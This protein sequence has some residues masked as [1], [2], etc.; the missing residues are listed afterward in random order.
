MRPRSG[1]TRCRRPSR[2]PSGTRGLLTVAS[3][4]SVQVAPERFVIHCSS[5]ERPSCRASHTRQPWRSCDE[6][7][8]A[9]SFSPFI[10]GRQFSLPPEH[11]AGERRLCRQH[12]IASRLAERHAIDAVGD[13]P[14]AEP[15]LAVEARE[16]TGI[17]FDTH[18]LRFTRLQLHALEAEQ[19]QTFLACG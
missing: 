12:W 13:A 17:G 18:A 7:W 5:T 2:T 8:R 16:E 19:P 14:L 3:P 6:T 15:V 9:T 10:C 11:T 1:K 4:G